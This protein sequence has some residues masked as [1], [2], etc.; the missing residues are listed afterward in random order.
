MPSVSLIVLRAL[1]EEYGVR[2]RFIGRRDMLPPDV[3]EA[4]DDMESMTSGN[5]KW[6]LAHH[7][8]SGE[9]R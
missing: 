9:A 4:V 3:L 1:L 5:T 6:V 8:R 7:K 2:I